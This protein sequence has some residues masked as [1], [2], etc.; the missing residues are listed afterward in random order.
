[1]AGAAAAWAAGRRHGTSGDRRTAAAIAPCSGH[2]SDLKQ[3]AACSG[4]ALE[5]CNLH[6]TALAALRHGQGTLHG[7]Q[8]YGCGPAERGAA[9]D[10]KTKCAPSS[11]CPQAL[12]L[13]LLLAA[14]PAAILA[15]DGKPGAAADGGEANAAARA[16]RP[17]PQA[18]DPAAADSAVEF[19]DEA[20]VA[21]AVNAAALAQLQV[22]WRAST[23]G[24]RRYLHH[25]GASP[26][27]HR[28]RPAW[29]ALLPGLCRIR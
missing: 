20:D 25:A 28:S 23:L 3:G 4:R 5:P 6:G 17:V 18:A 15:A 12:L 10:R 21:K 8:L 29:R 7:A 26:A 19:V 16:A 27:P 22:R 11:P 13:A 9:D 24:R 2:P 1:M 14:A